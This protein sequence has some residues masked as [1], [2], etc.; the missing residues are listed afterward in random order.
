MLFNRNLPTRCQK[1]SLSQG[2]YFM[3]CWY[4]PQY[5]VT[6]YR[7][8]R[9]YSIGTPI[10]AGRRSRQIHY[11]SLVCHRRQSTK[12][13]TSNKTWP[14][15]GQTSLMNQRQ[16]NTRERGREPRQGKFTTG[17]KMAKRDRR[18][19]RKNNSFV[20]DSQVMAF[21]IGY[22]SECYTFTRQYTTTLQWSGQSIQQN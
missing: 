2:I 10:G 4:G 14:E 9:A 13:Y 18:P 16:P 8:L 11:H 17:D 3:D 7:M 12:Q 5:E 6:P 21:R 15:K 22:R 19:V 1:T 20:E